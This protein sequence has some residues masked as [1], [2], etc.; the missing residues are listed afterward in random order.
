VSRVAASGC[1]SLRNLVLCCNTGKSIAVKTG[2]VEVLLAA[3]NNHLSSAVLCQNAV[4]ALLSMFFWGSKGNPGQLICLGGAA[5]IAKVKN[6]WP[7]DIKVQAQ[8]R[9]LFTLTADELNSWAGEE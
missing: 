7:D 6:K 5:A 3:V 9:S 1:S 8:V 4:C 2:G